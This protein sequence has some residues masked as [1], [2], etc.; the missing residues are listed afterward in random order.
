MIPN[1]IIKN[2]PKTNLKKLKKLNKV[3]LRKF[4]S[5]KT[6]KRMNLFLMF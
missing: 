2:K 1:Q 3:F 6:L 4:L 5:V